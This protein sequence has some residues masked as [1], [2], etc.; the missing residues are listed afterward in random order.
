ME[1]KFLLI[2]SIVYLFSIRFLFSVIDSG[3]DITFPKEALVLLLVHLIL[4]FCYNRFLSKH[5]SFFAFIFTSFSIIGIGFTYVPLKDL[6]YQ[7]LALANMSYSFSYPLLFFSGILFYTLDLKSKRLIILLSSFIWLI[8]L[9][10]ILTFI[11]DSLY[12]F[13]QSISYIYLSEGLAITFLLFSIFF[14]RGFRILKLVLLSGF[15]LLPSRSALILSIVSTI[16]QNL[17]ILLFI[18]FVIIVLF[19]AHVID[20]NILNDSIS[21]RLFSFGENDNSYNERSILFSR[22]LK[23]IQNSPIFGAFMGDYVYRNKQ[24]GYFHNFLWIYHYYGLIP[25]LIYLFLLIKLTIKSLSSD[26]KYRAVFLFVLGFSMVRGPGNYSLIFLMGFLY[27]YSS[28]LSNHNT[29]Y[30]I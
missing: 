10:L 6:E 27:A 17:R 3:L 1:K 21:N 7:S 20:I 29:S 15:L 13:L 4:V 12:E 8:T 2:F 23:D 18:I 16:R 14:F 24:G 26:L 22:N 11:Q 9:G 25:F 19:S 5:V 28:N 30:T